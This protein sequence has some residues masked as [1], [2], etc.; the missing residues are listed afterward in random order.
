MVLVKLCSSYL[1]AY[2]LDMSL[3]ARLYLE[4]RHVGLYRFSEV[5]CWLRC[6]R[7]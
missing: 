5:E 1:L 4:L 7:L 3:Y 2:L 6:W